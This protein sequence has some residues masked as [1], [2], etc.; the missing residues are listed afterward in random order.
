MSSE[1]HNSILKARR[2]QVRVT[3]QI[4]AKITGA[5]EKAYNDIE[6]LIADLDG[7]PRKTAKRML[8]KYKKDQLAVI[9]GELRNGYSQSLKEGMTLSALQA[10]STAQ[11]AERM[12]L[13]G[14]EIP[15]SPEFATIP[16]RAVDAVWKRMDS[17][18]LTLSD[19][20]WSLE[21]HT[22]RRIDAIV[23]SGIARGQSAVDM[24]KEL[25]FDILGIKHPGQ[26]PESLRWTERISKAVRARGT[27]HYNA[28]RLA[29]T[30]ISNAYHEADIMAAKAS[31]I[32]LGVKWNLSPSH[33][34][35]DVCDLLAT[36][37]VYGLGPG[38]Y[39]P[40]AAPLIPH[41]NDM[42]FVTRVLRPRA[43]WGKDLGKWK[44]RTEFTF[45]HPETTS[46][47]DATRKKQITLTITDKYKKT[48][49]E[50]FFRMQ[51]NIVG[52]KRF[53]TVPIKK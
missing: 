16:L 35:Y 22:R 25:Q 7:D 37:N 19:R 36:Q 12:M 6:R 1:Y 51:Q 40:E 29:R 32:V 15:V 41:P 53:K 23:M 47:L 8:W 9:T 45:K 17:K 24:A 33:G 28:L 10:S 49:E 18:G 3:D 34:K 27:I 2:N 4:I 14:T 43:L 21:K 20:I 39:P 44:P 42:C 38:V 5:L 52:A 31:K 48:I 30:E 46:Y 11:V 50:Q 13:A 26:I